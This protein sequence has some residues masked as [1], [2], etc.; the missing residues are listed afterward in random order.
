MR[1]LF[2]GL[3][4]LFLAAICFAEV[5]TRRDVSGK[6]TV[7]V[8]WNTTYMSRSDNSNHAELW[9][10]S[11]G[12]AEKQTISEFYMDG[13]TYAILFTERSDGYVVAE[14]IFSEELR[15]MLEQYGFTRA[16]YNKAKNQYADSCKR[17]KEYI[18]DNYSPHKQK[19]V[20]CKDEISPM[21]GW[22]FGDHEVILDGKKYTLM[23][24]VYREQKG[25]VYIDLWGTLE[26]WLY[27]TITY[28]E[29]QSDMIYDRCVPNWIEEK[30]Y[31]ID[32]KKIYIYDPNDNNIAPSVK[33][34]MKQR[35]CNVSITLDSSGPRVYINE[36]FVKTDSYKTTVYCLIK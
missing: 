18:R 5:K 2:L 34:L 26:Y 10:N 15:D 9:E 7:D 6:T 11:R 25:S 23:K 21:D 30:G 24:D 17:Y 1:K 29:G 33:A 12:K 31:K 14:F 16:E 19:K 35:G 4:L 20:E 3:T 22:D 27:D 32:Y 13:I 8:C 28:M 36:Y